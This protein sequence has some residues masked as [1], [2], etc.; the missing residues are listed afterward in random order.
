HSPLMKKHDV[1]TS[2]RLL[3]KFSCNRNSERPITTQEM[4]EIH[5]FTSKLP[6]SIDVKWGIADVPELGDK[7]KVTILASGFDLTLVDGQRVDGAADTAGN[8]DNVV[9]FGDNAESWNE[10]ATF[11]SYGFDT[12]H[13]VSDFPSL[14][15]AEGG[16]GALFSYASGII[17]RL[18][19]PFF[20]ELLTVSMHV[21]FSDTRIPASALNRHIL[22]SPTLP[23]VERDYLAMV[24]YFDSQLGIFLDRLHRDG[25]LDDTMILIM[26]D[27]SQDMSANSSAETAPVRMTMMAV[28]CGITATIHRT[29][30][31]IDLYP[32]I[33]N[34][35]GST[36]PKGWRGA[37]HSALSPAINAA[38]THDRGL[39]NDHPADT[40]LTADTL[41]R[42]DTL[43]TARIIQAPEIS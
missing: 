37:G 12:I 2:Q 6:A 24:S 43:P 41:H 31:Q 16:D 22:D 40:L 17:P 11:S 35:T 28:N 14:A 34:L 5:A 23:P 19:R 9:I 15:D 21:P 3:L 29:V 20:L 7:L 42:A 39:I 32:T 13:S 30:G 8:I 18:S 25:I 4:K 27:H 36:G 1:N 26:S 33:L 10:R 38:Y